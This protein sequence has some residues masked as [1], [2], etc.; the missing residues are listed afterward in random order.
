MHRRFMLAGAMGGGLAILLGAFGAH[1][2][3]SITSDE[4]IIRGFQTGVQ[5]QFYHSLALLI[6]V[7]FRHQSI[8]R[9]LNLACSC[10]LIGIV[11]FSGSLYLLSYLKIEDSSAVRFVGPI[12]PV[13]GIFFI[14]G[15]FFLLIAFWNK[16][17]QNGS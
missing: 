13:G 14:A 6:V 11:L 3:E 2:L 15:W 4:K 16:K 8:N 7:G 10:W 12:T 9:W 1:G 17:D 5:Y